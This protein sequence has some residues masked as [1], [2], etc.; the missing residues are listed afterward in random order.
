MHACTAKTEVAIC[1][2]YR[3]FNHPVPKDGTIRE[4]VGNF[5]SA[6]DRSLRKSCI[7]ASILRIQFRHDVFRYLF[8]NKKELVLGDFD[9]HYFPSGYNQWCRQYGTDD[10]PSYYGH[11]IVFLLKV[12]TY[13]QWTRRNSVF[14]LPDRTLQQKQ[15][16]FLEMIRVDVIKKNF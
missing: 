12:R 15:R 1:Y 14:K 13:L 5:T 4:A 10:N 11:S 6:M 16:T 9:E 2:Y 8:G 7:R 3:K